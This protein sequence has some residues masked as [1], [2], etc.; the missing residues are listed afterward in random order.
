MF[1]SLLSVGM[2]RRLG[3][4]QLPSQCRVC[5]AWPAQPVC[6]ACVG[7]F[8]QPQPRCRT[9]AMPLPFQQPGVLRQCGACLKKPPPL[10]RCLAAVA[11]AYPWS[12]LIQDFKFHAEPGL[13][14]SFAT[15]LRAAP[16]VE[17]ALEAA[18]LLLPM[19]LSP[20]RMKERGYNQAL[21]LARRLEPR[22][23]R[24][25]L[26]LRIQDTPAQHTLKRSARLTALD[27]A[28]VVEPL[29]ISALKGRSV[30]LVDDVMTTGTSLFTAARV[31]KAAGA[32]QVTGL[33]VAR[34]E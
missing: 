1:A 21:L 20:R 12:G 4:L 15:L 19:P 18:D 14:R 31:L 26:L 2:F 8:A 5:H 13:V 29:L 23:T 28:F 24:A 7:Q 16:W 17:P 27:H 32:A 10:E 9:C 6:E 33:V 34:T 30:V 3:R 22:K 25:D 11:Y